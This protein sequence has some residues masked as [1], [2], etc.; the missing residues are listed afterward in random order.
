MKVTQLL[1]IY[2]V[3]VIK[4]HTWS[5][6]VLSIGNSM[7]K[8]NVALFGFTVISNNNLNSLALRKQLRTSKVQ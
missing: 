2:I 8:I 6:R 3:G 1:V 5:N 7:V 4:G